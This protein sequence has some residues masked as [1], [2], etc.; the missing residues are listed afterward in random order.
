M[1]LSI[2]RVS[3]N[4]TAIPNGGSTTAPKVTLSGN[5]DTPGQPVVVWDGDTQL[6]LVTADGTNIY[7]DVDLPQSKAYVFKFT[8]RDGNNPS[9]T[10]TVNKS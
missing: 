1:A 2:N 5:T 6:G 9:N 8:T 3:A 4:G 7:Y 10:W